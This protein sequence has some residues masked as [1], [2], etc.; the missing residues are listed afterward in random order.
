MMRNNKWKLIASSIAILAPVIFGLVFWNRLPESMNVH[1]GMNGEAD[2]SASKA[3]AVFFIPCMLLAVHWFCIFFTA[4]DPKNKGQN[5]KVFSMVL[6]I[7]PLISAFS[8]GLIYSMALGVDLRMESLMLVM[9]GSMFV[10]I[11][12]YLPKCRQNHTIGIKI[13]WTLEDEE[14]WNATHRMAGWVWVIGGLLLCFCIFLPTLILPWV[15]I[16]L[17]AVLALIPT[18]YSYR[19][20]KKQRK[21]GKTPT[22]STEESEEY[23]KKMRVPSIAVLIFVV[24]MLIGSAVIC[25]TGNIEMIKGEDALTVKASYYEDLTV[26]YEDIDALEYRENFEFGSRAY[27]FG[28]P[29]LS[30][31]TFENKELGKYTLYAYTDCKSCVLLKIDEKVLVLGCE[32]AQE[33]KALYEALLEMTETAQDSK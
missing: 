14:N 30:M 24:L 4:K 7:T 9:M 21:A 26:R 5:K 32:S 2:G 16:V 29:R 17:M 33:G 19:F 3:F 28:T 25:F 20:Y 10:L 27:G 11:G 31:G 18:L 13:K 23:T 15:L 1:W 22:A 6:W 12:N 8:S